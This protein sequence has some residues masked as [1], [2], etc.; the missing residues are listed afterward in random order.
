LGFKGEIRSLSLSLSLSPL[1]IDL[2]QTL[3]YPIL[4]TKNARENKRKLMGC[5]FQRFFPSSNEN[6]NIANFALPNSSN[7]KS[8]EKNEMGGIFLQVFL[9]K[10]SLESESFGNY[11]RPILVTQMQERKKRNG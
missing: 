6:E 4:S 3:Y 11:V 5:V 9:L 2:F 8:K 10:K 7:K 1:E